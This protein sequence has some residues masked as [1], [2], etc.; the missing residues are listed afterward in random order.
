[1]RHSSVTLAYM[2]GWVA[3][4]GPLGWVPRVVFGDAAKATIGRYVTP[5]AALVTKCM[6]T[7]SPGVSA[8]GFIPP[9]YNLGK[10]AIQKACGWYARVVTRR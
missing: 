1:M 9:T 2:C 7:L 5:T 6:Y 8:G 3:A 4:H 10:P